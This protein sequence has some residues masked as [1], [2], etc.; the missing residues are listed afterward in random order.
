MPDEFNS[1]GSI[2]YIYYG[3]ENIVISP[4]H[5]FIY[6]MQSIAR[7][8]VAYGHPLYKSLAMNFSWGKSFFFSN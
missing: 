1:F 8:G 3:Q 6:V 5:E 2:K 4:C 7:N